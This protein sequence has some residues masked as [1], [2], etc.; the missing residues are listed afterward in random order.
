MNLLE[1]NQKMQTK[2]WKIRVAALCL[3]VGV[4]STCL[5]KVIYVDAN[6]PGAGDGTSWENA[7]SY[8]RDALLFAA[9]G[10]EIRVAKGIYRPDQG[11]AVTE[12]NQ[13]ATFELINGLTIMG[14]YAGYGE[15]DPNARDIAQYETILSGDLDDNDAGVADPCD[16]LH[17]PTRSDNSYHVVTGNGTDSSAVLD[18]FTIIGGQANDYYGDGGG[19]YCRNCSPTLLDCTF[20]G[21]SARN[22]CGGISG[23]G[24]FFNCTFIG[25][26]AGDGGAV[27]WGGY[28]TNC[29]FIGNS[30]YYGGGMFG[31]GYLISCTFRRNSAVEM[32]GA[33]AAW[34][35]SGA[36]M[37]NCI[38]EE[39]SARS[40]GAIGDFEADATRLNDCIFIRNSA[41]NGGGMSLL[42][43][44]VATVTNCAFV[45][46][47]A[48]DNGGGLQDWYSMVCLTNC[49]FRGNS[50]GNHGGGVFHEVGDDW[51]SLTLKECS[52]AGNTAEKG[53]ALACHIRRNGPAVVQLTNC[54]LWDGGYVIWNSEDSPI[55]VSYS[56]IRGGQASIY[57]PCDAVVCGEGNV[58]ADPCFAALGYW[59][60]NETPEDANDDFWVDGDCH[61]KSQG[62]R[63]DPNSQSWVLDDVTS[64]CIDAG[65]PM[66]P[67][68]LEP[69][70][71][72][73]V[74]NMGAYGGT[75]EASK[76]YFAK[77]PCEVIAAG[78]INGDC[79]VDF[80]DFVLMALHW[81]GGR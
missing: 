70:P 79:A 80:K 44:S 17:E 58:D 43:G 38:F 12:G 74:V 72:G 4:A 63:W 67:I 56:D 28:F 25:N 42:G 53:N 76:S 22:E 64:P 10:D 81:L 47:S 35:S 19:M 29:T 32:G 2:K 14:G 33:I 16:L 36:T 34:D 57:D 3:C 7:C 71:N 13:S 65:D 31:D 45:G 66:S 75:A 60:P 1:R 68:G 59:N 23:W 61:L 39:N 69:F 41:E 77:P 40:G 15:P 37:V 24:I 48:S 49:S 20:E 5:G 46:N 21:N 51:N 11:A 27:N 8:L 54:I 55:T 9:A 62:G 26:S 50:A 6:A 78:D 52:F 73:G 30:A 18:G